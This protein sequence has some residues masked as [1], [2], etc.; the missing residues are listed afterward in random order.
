MGLNPKTTTLSLPLNMKMLEKHIKS[1]ILISN[2]NLDT[3]SLLVMNNEILNIILD[4]SMRYTF[5][6]NDYY[7][8]M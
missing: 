7:G 1:T 3:R 5:N 6:V 2:A 4:I 8:D